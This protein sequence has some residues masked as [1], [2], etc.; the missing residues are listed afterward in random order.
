MNSLNLFLG[1]LA[2]AWGPFQFP[3]APRQ[4]SEH[5]PHYDLLFGV[6][7]LLTIFFTVVVIAL[8]VVLAVRYRRGNK[9][10][11]SNNPVHNT[12]LELIWMGVPLILALAI[13]LWSAINF[14]KVRTMPDDGIEIFCIGKQWMWHF[15]HPNGIREN[16]ELHIPVGVPI[17]MTMISQDVIH[18]MYLPEMRAQ[19]HVVPGRYTQ[20][21]FT[22]TKP[23][24]YKILCAM[25]C[26]TQHSEMVGILYVLSQEDYGKWQEKGG[27][28]YAADAKTLE[29]RGAKLWKEKACGN[30]HTNVDNPRAPTLANFIG[31]PRKLD[32]GTTVIADRDYF[33]ESVVNPHRAIVAGYENTMPVYGGQLTEENVISL[34]EY[35][36]SGLAAG[37]NYDRAEKSADETSKANS[38][39][40]DIANKYKS[41]GEAQ[42]RE[43]EDKR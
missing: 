9:V 43:A 19:Y 36:K 16:N 6:I 26:G 2:E 32:D 40:V 34:F 22:P 33:R 23:G 11:R 25:H 5:A 1:G 14:V 17:K 13:F 8:M 24:K 38:S 12:A 37:I 29:E 41:A 4:A 18:A 31:K 7:S 10:N 28:R 27:N 15:Q 20:L 30:C 21:A 35:I 39:P 42:F 3:I